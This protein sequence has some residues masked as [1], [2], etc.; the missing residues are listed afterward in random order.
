MVHLTWSRLYK[1][2]HTC[3]TS[4]FISK[5]GLLSSLKL[6]IS[7]PFYKRNEQVGHVSKMFLLFMQIKLVKITTEMEQCI[8]PTRHTYSN[9]VKRLEIQR[10]NAF[11]RSLARQ[12]ESNLSLIV[13]IKV[14]KTTIVEFANSVDLDEA[15]HNEPP[16]LEIHFLIFCLWILNM[17]GFFILK[18]CR[19]KFCNLPLTLYKSKKQSFSSVHYC[20]TTIKRNQILTL[21]GEKKLWIILF[22]FVFGRALSYRFFCFVDVVWTAT[23]GNESYVLHFLCHRR[24]RKLLLSFRVNM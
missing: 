13:R 9:E 20:T 10:M 6:S 22:Q 14:Q 17:I 5:N 18:F 4:G 24:R 19:L 8:R 15:A 11:V 2:V 23:N 16:H 3:S 12:S 21:Y 1:P 7:Q